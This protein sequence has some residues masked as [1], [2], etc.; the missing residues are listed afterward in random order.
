MANY[1]GSGNRFGNDTP[2]VFNLII[3]NV[4]VFLAQQLIK[5]F[6]ITAWGSLYYFTSSNFKPHQF[7]TSMFLHGDFGHIMFNMFSL[8]VFGSILERVWG[9]KKFLLFYMV[10]G[11][12]AGLLYQFL[13]PYDANKFAEAYRTI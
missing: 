8:Y 3:A 6:D 4:L 9:A 10:C 11:I 7:I 5:Q 2:I 12:G 13:M 1:F